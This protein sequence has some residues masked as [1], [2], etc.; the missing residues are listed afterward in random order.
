MKLSNRC[1]LHDSSPGKCLYLNRARKI[2]RFLTITIPFLLIMPASSSAGDVSDKALHFGLSAAFGGISETYLHHKTNL[3]PAKRIAAGTVIG[4]IPGLFKEV[5][6]GSRDNNVFSG[7][8]MAANIAGACTGSIAAHF[9]N[10]KI[11]IGVSRRNDET[12]ISLS[13]NF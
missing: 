2:I 13:F 4:S 1:K 10:K 8:D 3:S 9:I 7:E 6:D 12:E 5:Y 11:R